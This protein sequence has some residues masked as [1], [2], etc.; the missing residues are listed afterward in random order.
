VALDVRFPTD[1]LVLVTGATGYTGAVLTRKLVNL[2][3]RVR[4]VARASSDVSQFG[5]LPIEWVR[6]D[7]FDEPTVEKAVAGVSYVFHV[8]AAYREPN[9][10]DE[11][12]SLV[13]VESTRLLAKHVVNSSTLKR[14]VHIS[15][16]GVHGHIDEPPA[17]EDYRFS[18][19]DIYQRTKAEGEWFIRSFAAENKLPLAVVRPAAIYG[20]GDKRLLKLFK[21]AAKPVFP[22][23]GKGRGLY[24]LIHVDDLTDIFIT[25][26]LHPAAEG[27]VFIAGN[28]EPSELKEV[29]TTIASEIDNSSLR[30]IRFPAWPLF[31]S[32][33]ICEWVCRPLRI[34]PPLYRRRVAFFTKDRAFDTARL[35]NV[36]GYRYSVSVEEGLRST[37]RWYR[38]KG[39][40]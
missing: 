38:E 39:W 37:A 22:L 35:R 19:G 24:H 16:V 28:A 2:G 17:N 25:A 5:G 3:C 34:D 8:A 40:L 33:D 31:L 21:M 1:S 4:A 6:G 9:I 30:F 26:A 11:V 7:V 10:S 20:P 15:T 29:A 27:G 13:H 18:P 12:Y 36:L 14:F 32:A 23:F